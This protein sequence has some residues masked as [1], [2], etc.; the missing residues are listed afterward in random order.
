MCHVG[1]LQF[2]SDF[3]PRWVDVCCI[4][5][6]FFDWPTKF[7]FILTFPSSVTSEFFFKENHN[8]LCQILYI[9]RAAFVN[10]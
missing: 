2:A 10:H 7:I 1:Q 5:L 4:L 3:L 8:I 9:G 6:L